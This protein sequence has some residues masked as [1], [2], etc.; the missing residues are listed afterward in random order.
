MWTINNI[1]KP[2]TDVGKPVNDSAAYKPLTNT[3]PINKALYIKS[4]IDDNF[5][6]DAVEVNPVTGQAG[7][8]VQLARLNYSRGQQWFFTA[9]GYVQSGLKAA[10]GSDL[11]LVVENPF[12]AILTPDGS[13]QDR[14]NYGLQS[15]DD[16][17][18]ISSKNNTV[19]QK[20]TLN[21]QGNLVSKLYHSARGIV[22]VLDGLFSPDGKGFSV[23]LNPSNDSGGQ[24]WTIEEI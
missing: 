10:D 21:A 9:D 4:N 19:A 12:T 5:V 14:E 13:L 22:Y 1:G 24:I 7:S 17:L 18:Q 11:V 8:K 3:T 16:I 6:L 23:Q 2:V 15:R 20:W